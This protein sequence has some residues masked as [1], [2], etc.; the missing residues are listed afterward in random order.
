MPSVKICQ[1][2]DG[3]MLRVVHQNDKEI[4]FTGNIG[5]LQEIQEWM[6]IIMDI[7]KRNLNEMTNL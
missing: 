3:K 2:K 5:G 7:Y 6:Q 1:M 4:I